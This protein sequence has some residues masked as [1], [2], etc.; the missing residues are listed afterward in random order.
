MGAGR[1]R[2]AA[3]FT[4]PGGLR[5]VSYPGQVSVSAALTRRQLQYLGIGQIEIKLDNPWKLSF[6]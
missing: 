4:H 3:A 6:Q 1:G 5:P 2:G